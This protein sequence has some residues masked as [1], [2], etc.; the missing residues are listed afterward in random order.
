VIVSLNGQR[1][2]LPVSEHVDVSELETL[3]PF[4]FLRVH[5]TELIVIGTCRH[6]AL[7]ARAMGE[8]VT[9]QAYL[10]RDRG[11]V[12]VARFGRDEEVVS[13][14]EALRAREFRSGDRLVLHRDNPGWAI[15]AVPAQKLESK[16]EIPIA[17][18]P[19]CLDN[20]AGLG[21]L[22]AQLL[23]DLLPR[24]IYKE[25][26]DDF[27]L[28]PIKGI[29]LY[30]YKPGMG[31]TALVRA[32]A[33]SFYDLGQIRGFDVVLY[34]IQP[35]ALKSMWHGED[36]RL[37]RE[38][39]F[40]TIQERLRRPRTRPLIVIAAFD[41]V[42]SL[43]RRVGGHDTQGYLSP[44]QNDVVQAMLGAMDGIIPLQAAE[45][46][47]ADVLFIGT[48]NRPDGL[49]EGLKRAGRFGDRIYEFP[50]YDADCAA[51]IM[52]VYAHG[53]P[54]YLDDGIRREVPP[55]EI[56]E[57]ILRPATAQ[58]F[59]CPV[60][61]YATEGRATIDVTAGQALAGVH[62]KAAMS[63]AKRQAAM[64]ALH[65]SG[66]AAVGF[67]DVV[68]GLWREA[69]VVAGQLDADRQSLAR[70]LKIRVPILRT[71]L[72]PET[73]FARHRYLRALSS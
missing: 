36:G 42:D 63:N 9:F 53:F 14:C 69:R 55:G 22:K 48:T 37:V 7:H 34:D 38:E 41:E 2:E 66:P 51:E 46:P 12:R 24:L 19:T 31:K 18:L 27:Q 59:P 23:D 49:D 11:L 71:E 10:D 17:G 62:Y 40:G 26:A 39:V 4:E 3:A 60:L 21:E 15:N 56:L 73:E 29:I 8:T 32:L 68:E 50:D 67:E 64:R 43:G 35:T 54:W 45:G 72:V 47:A 1:R 16:F 28:D 25:I 5:P 61:R 44:A 6:Q 20:L 33:R 57:R 52:Q 13:L 30:S 70:Q 65:R 58:V